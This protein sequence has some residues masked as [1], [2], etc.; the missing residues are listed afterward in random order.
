MQRVLSEMIAAASLALL[1][2]MP[3][4]NDP[5]SPLELYNLADDPQETLNLIH[6]APQVAR[7]MEAALRTHIRRGGA[8]PWQR[9]ARGDL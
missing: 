9:P 7:E 1:A 8:V 6:R 4:Q 3:P 5:Y 2:D